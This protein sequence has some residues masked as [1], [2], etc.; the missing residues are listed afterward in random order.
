MLSQKAC[1]LAVLWA[2]PKPCQDLDLLS[3]PCPELGE[4]MGLWAEGGVPAAAAAPRWAPSKGGWAGGGLVLSSLVLPSLGT[5]GN[6]SSFSLRFS[7]LAAKSS[8][9]CFLG[10]GVQL[11]ER[12]VELEQLRLS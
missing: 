11:E 6:L 2:A 5:K 7:T 8:M 9:D 12:L 10:D 1:C 4:P 3:D